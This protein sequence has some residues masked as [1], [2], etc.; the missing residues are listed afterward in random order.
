MNNEEDETTISSKVLDKFPSLTMTTTTTTE[1]IGEQDGENVNEDQMEIDRRNEEEG[2]GE[3]IVTPWTVE[4]M[5]DK[6]IDYD[7]L[8]SRFGSQRIDENLINRLEKL[9]NR[10]AHHLIRRGIVF[11]HRDLNYILDLYEQKKPFY[12][13]TGRG[14]S[15]SSMHLGHLIP[16]LFT[17]YLQDVFDVPLIVQMTDDEKYLWKDLTMDELTEMT[18]ENVRDIIA[19]GFDVEKTFIFSNFEYMSNSKSFYQTICRISRC[20]NINQVKNIFGFDD[21]YSIGK[22]AFPAVQAAPAFSNSF[23]Q[24]FGDNNNSVP[25]LIPCAIDQDPYFLLTRNIAPRLNFH[26]PALI[27]STFIPALQGAKSKMSASDS[28]TSI[29]LSDTQNQIKK[30]I[31]KYAFS[32]GRSTIEDHRKY[33]GD[34]SIDVSFQYLKYFIQ[35]DNELNEIKK[36][37]EKGDLLSGELKAIIIKKIQEEISN[38]QERRIKITDEQVRQ[39]MTIRKLKYDFPIVQTN[40]NKKSKKSKKK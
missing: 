18:K 9:T 32:G 7:K 2:K 15:S 38:F 37:Y 20:I 8:I 28:T 14:P 1:M 13:Y 30:K 11:S 5:N 25:C 22:V 10:P 27:H 39:Y 3:D 21:S 16:F 26:K 36:N 12:L 17:K 33:G 35:N 34:T 6:G 40:S 24:I 29:Y 4:S 19:C 31:N 23:P